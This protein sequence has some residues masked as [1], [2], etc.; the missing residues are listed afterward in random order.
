MLTTGLSPDGTE[1]AT[2]YIASG[3]MPAE[4]VEAM[5]MCDVSELPPFDAMTTAGLQL[6]VPSE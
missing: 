4:I 5:T 3:F 6:C 1:P 2:H